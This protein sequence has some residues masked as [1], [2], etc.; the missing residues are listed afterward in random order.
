MRDP[1][2]FACPRCDF[3]LVPIHAVEGRKRRVVALTC[4]EPYCDH[5][6]MVPR[7]LAGQLERDQARNHAH[8][9]VRR[10]AE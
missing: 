3:P 2:R 1:K 4:P 8:A 9:A 6:Q 5:M 7:R 10:A